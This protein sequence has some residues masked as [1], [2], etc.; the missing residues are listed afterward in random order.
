[1]AGNS[2]GIPIMIQPNGFRGVLSG[3]LTVSGGSRDIGFAVLPQGAGAHGG[4]SPIMV[5]GYRPFTLPLSPGRYLVFFDNRH[6]AI[7]GKTL[8]VFIQVRYE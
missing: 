4:F 7:I 5:Y 3:E 1:M 6:A 2:R 8:N